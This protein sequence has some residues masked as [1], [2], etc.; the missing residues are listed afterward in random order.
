M[1]ESVIL[2]PSN[3]DPGILFQVPVSTLSDNEGNLYA[4]VHLPLYSGSTL[5]LYRHVPAP[6]FL[7]N[8]SVILDVES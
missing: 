7:E 2:L 8:S 3:E 6:F 4:V 1:L 5:K